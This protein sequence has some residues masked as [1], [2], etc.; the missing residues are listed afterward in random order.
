VFVTDDFGGLSNAASV[1]AEQSLGGGH[2]MMLAVLENG[3]AVNG[4]ETRGEFIAIGVDAACQVFDRW[5]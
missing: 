5:G 1:L 3:F 2:A 4:S